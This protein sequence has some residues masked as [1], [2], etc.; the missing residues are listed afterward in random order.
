LDSVA[1]DPLFLIDVHCRGESGSGL[2]SPGHLCDRMQIF[3]SLTN[4]AV[5]WTRLPKMTC[6][7]VLPKAIVRPQAN[8]K[9]TIIFVTHRLSTVRQ[10][11][12]VAMFENGTITEFG[13]HSDLLAKDGPYAAL[14]KA[15]MSS[16]PP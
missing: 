6:L 10:A 7:S 2:L 15:F 9:S 11:H 1:L 14:Y 16:D 8:K 3:A 4:R 13:T 12:K 5:L